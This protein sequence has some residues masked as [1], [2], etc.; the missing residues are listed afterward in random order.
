VSEVTHGEPSNGDAT[1]WTPNAGELSFTT[2]IYYGDAGSATGNTL[3]PPTISEIGWT[4]VLA[5]SVLGRA[6]RSMLP[7]NRLCV[8]LNLRIDWTANSLSGGEFVRGKAAVF[9]FSGGFALARGELWNAEGVAI[10]SCVGRFK[11]TSTT[12]AEADAAIHEVRACSEATI[13]DFLRLRVV[14][15]SSGRSTTSFRDL[16][17]F[18]NPANV[19]HGGVQSAMFDTVARHVAGLDG[20]EWHVLDLDVQFLDPVFA[21]AAQITIE[22]IV[23]GRSRNIARVGMRILGTDG[24]MS[25]ASATLCRAR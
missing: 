18:A 7:P 10:A 4:A 19:V 21:A 2:S 13:G 9:D 23:L 12:S 24:P 15:T 6:V 5:D 3:V 14:S 11:I 22:G 25:T 16:G 1:M 17:P 20:G 8:T